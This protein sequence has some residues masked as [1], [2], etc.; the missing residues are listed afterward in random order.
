[1]NLNKLFQ[2]AVAGLVAAQIPLLSAEKTMAQ[3]VNDLSSF[4]CQIS[5]DDLYVTLALRKNG[6][7]SDPMIVWKTEEFSSSGYTPE[8]RCNEV[9]NR[10]NAILDENGGTLSGLY[11]TAGIVNG[12]AV[13]CA[14]NNTRSGCNS[15][16]MLFTLNQDNRR[17]PS[18]M[19]RSIASAGVVGSGNVIQE[20][21]GQPYLNLEVLVNEL[22]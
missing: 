22:F 19:L 12:E 16:N 14:V 13:L 17:N 1:M 21:G 18:R 11:M 4:Q 3:A 10:L 9:T 6:A 20:S 5:T 8:R 15:R 2:C 7:V